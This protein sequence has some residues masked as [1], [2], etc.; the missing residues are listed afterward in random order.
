MRTYLLPEGGRQ[1][2]ANLH[3]HSTVSDGCM[4][5]EEL[6][7]LYSAEG[8][9]VL[10]YTDHHVQV[11]Q[12][13]L[14]DESFLALTGVEI[15]MNENPA[16]PRWGKVCHVCLIAGEEDH[17]LQELHYPNQYEA[18]NKELLHYDESLP[19]MDRTYTPENI[20]AIMTAAREYGY[21]VTYNHPAWSGESYPQYIHYDGMHAMEM[22]NFGSCVGGQVDV[23]ERV[24]DDMLAAGKRIFCVADDDNH[25]VHP[26]ESRLWDS[27]GGFTM[28]KAERLDYPSIMTALKSGN[29]YASQAPEIHDLWLEDGE[30]HI[31]CSNADLIR[32]KCKYRA[33]AVWAADGTPLTEASFKITPEDV[34]FRITVVDSNGKAA[35]TNAYFID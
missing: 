6:K 11:A 3:C 34:S 31:T 16:A 24:Y 7:R 21:F 27:F 9:S 29:F 2:K 20:S 17:L 33:Q 1:F 10:A 5:P 35:Y 18:K 12:N 32:L 23:N 8:Y 28:I 25:N 4:T 14:T 26:R 15:S 30:V 22:V 19:Q 13:H